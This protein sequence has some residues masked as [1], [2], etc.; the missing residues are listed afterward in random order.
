MQPSPVLPQPKPGILLG[1]VLKI[2]FVIYKDG[3]SQEV[4][5][6]FKIKRLT[7]KEIDAN[8]KFQSNVQTHKTKIR[9]K[10][11]GVKRINLM[12]STLRYIDIRGSEITYL[13]FCNSSKRLLLC[14]RKAVWYQGYP[15]AAGSGYY[16]QKFTLTTT[17]RI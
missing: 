15:A 5:G 13:K 17:Y 11:I 12:S 3:A 2:Y 9:R 16:A 1:A 10:K 7:F 4:R 8:S 6:D 14:Q